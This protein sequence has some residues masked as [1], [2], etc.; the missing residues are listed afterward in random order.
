M[1]DWVAHL[2]HLQSILLKYDS[3]GVLTKL[4]MLRYFR[5]SLKSSV[6]AEL[7]YWDLELESFDQMVKKIVDIKAKLALRP[8]SSTKKIDQNCLRGNW[9]ANSAVTKSQGSDMNDPR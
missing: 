8:P 7:E 2:E 3:V 6:L 4:T 5:E 1:L 9:L